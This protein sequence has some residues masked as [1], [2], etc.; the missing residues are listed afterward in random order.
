MTK[1]RSLLLSLTGILFVTT[2]AAQAADS[3][4]YLRDK[5]QAESLLKGKTLK[6][7]Y[8][9]TKSAY[10]LRFGADGALVNQAG[11]EGRW[12]VNDEAQYCREWTS[13]HLQGNKACMDLARTPGG[14]AIFHQGKKV[15]EGSLGN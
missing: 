13:G 12:W 4:E 9:R 1:A 10:V 11:A 5:A 2:V 7:V 15:A 3:P 14:I 6:G 8:L